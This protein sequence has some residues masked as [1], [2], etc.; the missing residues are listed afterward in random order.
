M[1][2]YAQ[3]ILAFRIRCYYRNSRC[4]VFTSILIGLDNISVR[5]FLKLW[6]T[7]G[8][9]CCL[10]MF[11]LK[12]YLPTVSIQAHRD[13]Q[14][15]KIPVRT[16][17]LR[18]PAARRVSLREMIIALA[19]RESKMGM[20]VVYELNLV[21]YSLLAHNNGSYCGNKIVEQGEECDCGSPK[22]CEAVDKCC[23][24]RNDALGIPGCTVRPEMQCR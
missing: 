8:K 9:L 15:N 12:V 19:R 16:Q 14:A 17:K 3:P 1:G 18:T 24:A 21:V 5:P 7:V 10:Y 11:I 2:N 13:S 20:L 22:E 23:V 4:Y 6:S